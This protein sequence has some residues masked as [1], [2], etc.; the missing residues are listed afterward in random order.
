MLASPGDVNLFKRL[1]NH[2]KVDISTEN[3]NRTSV[4][5]D[6]DDD[7]DDDDRA[8]HTSGLVVNEF[9]SSLKP[10]DD[11]VCRHDVRS[12][13]ACD[14]CSSERQKSPNDDRVDRPSRTHFSDAMAASSN[15][16]KIHSTPLHRTPRYPPSPPKIDPVEERRKQ[17]ALRSLF[18]KSKHIQLTR[19]FDM[20]DP[21]EVMLDELDAISS[22]EALDGF[23][24]IMGVVLTVLMSCLEMMNRRLGS[25]L[26]IDGLCDTVKNDMRKYD[27]VF[28]KVV[29]KYIQQGE[30]NP[31]MSLAFLI[32]GSIVTQHLGNS[33]SSFLGVKNNTVAPSPAEA[34]GVKPAKSAENP[35]MSMVGA[36]FENPDVLANIG[37]MF[38]EPSSNPLM[39]MFGSILTPT[40]SKPPPT[41]G[42]PISIQ[43]PR[44]QM[45]LPVKRGGYIPSSRAL[46]TIT[47]EEED[48]ATHM[49]GLRLN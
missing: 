32:F 11:E 36:L 41:N 45:P 20:N 10:Q 21:L 14:E 28:R 48:L 44:A 13:D 39:G 47:E 5:E 16:F 6:A 31:F 18:A 4:C 37:Q 22:E 46:P 1:S 2:E 3:I 42:T 15:N 38:K 24:S 33:V 35:M 19:E 7:D 23:V 29:S 8:Q 49:Q 43:T 26:S 34:G 17:A 30:S 27:A 9:L 12:R 40:S 25:P